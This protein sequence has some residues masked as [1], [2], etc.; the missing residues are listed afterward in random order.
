M[1]FVIFSHLLSTVGRQ[2][3]SCKCFSLFIANGKRVMLSA[4]FASIIVNIINGWDEEFLLPFCLP[5]QFHPFSFLSPLIFQMPNPSPRHE[6]R[7][8]TVATEGRRQT[9]AFHSLLNSTKLHAFRTFNMCVI[10]SSFSSPHL[11]LSI[12]PIPHLSDAAPLLTL[13]FY[14]HRERSLLGCDNKECVWSILHFY[15]SISHLC[16]LYAHE[17]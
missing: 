9:H 11:S 8:K 13:H 12:L 4:S 2:A 14:C 15:G 10:H 17:R 7:G 1:S 6:R 16:N 3:N 5:S